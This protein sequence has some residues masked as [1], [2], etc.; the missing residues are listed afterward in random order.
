M[1]CRWRFFAGFWGGFE[2]DFLADGAH[3]MEDCFEFSVVGDSVLKEVGLLW[4]E[5]HSDGLGLYLAGPAPMSWMV[6]SNAAMGEPTQ[7]CEF[8][9]ES[10]VAAL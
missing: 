10:L 5:R 2:E 3:F 9:F 8:L 6:G 1:F 7:G 4:R